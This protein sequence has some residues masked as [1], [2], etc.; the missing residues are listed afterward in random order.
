VKTLIISAALSVTTLAAPNLA[1]AQD[2]EAGQKV[3][4]RCVACH[5]V[6]EG[7]RNKAGPNL[8]GLFGSKAGSRKVGYKFSKVLT[9][10]EVVWDEDTLSTWIENPKKMVP[11]TRMNFGL[12]KPEQRADVIAY[13]KS[14]T[15]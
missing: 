1:H 7:G 5:T 4:K 15:Q 8:W 9:E 14:V 2:I 12:K 3:F 13:L 11:R 6:E 10:S